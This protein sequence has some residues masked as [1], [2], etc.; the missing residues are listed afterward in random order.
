MIVHLHGHSYLRQE[1]DMSEPTETP[2]P[3]YLTVQQMAA[4]TGFPTEAIRTAIRRGELPH[5]RL[6]KGRGKAY[7]VS[8]QAFEEWLREREQRGVEEPT[9]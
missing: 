7:W 3:R 4:E 8:R 6:G 1:I 9:E 2:A 5:M